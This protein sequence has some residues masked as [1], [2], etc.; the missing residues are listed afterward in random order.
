MGLWIFLL[1]FPQQP[2]E[3]IFPNSQGCAQPQG[4]LFP[5]MKLFNLLDGLLKVLDNGLSDGIQLP[6][7]FREDQPIFFT[8]EQFNSVKK[9]QGLDLPGH[10]RLRRVAQLGSPADTF[11]LNHKA[12]GFQVINVDSRSPLYQEENS[13]MIEAMNTIEQ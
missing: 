2:G 9:L 12:E 11:F 13:K 8:L 6:P 4:K 3:N 7:R 1:K 5:G 10:A